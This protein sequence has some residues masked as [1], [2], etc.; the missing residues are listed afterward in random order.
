MAYLITLLLAL[1]SFN[2]VIRWMGGAGKPC[3]FSVPG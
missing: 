2:R 3:I 1:T